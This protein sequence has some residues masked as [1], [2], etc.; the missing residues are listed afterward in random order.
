MAFSVASAASRSERVG[1]GGELDEDIVGGLGVK[2]AM[3]WSCSLWLVEG[4]RVFTWSDLISLEDAP[5]AGG[6][7]R[8]WTL[9]PRYLARLGARKI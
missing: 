1:S 2:W 6:M 3:S 5:Q 4:L 7:K 9:I 8:S